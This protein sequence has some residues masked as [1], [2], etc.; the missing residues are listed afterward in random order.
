[1]NIG[2]YSFYSFYNRNRLFLDCSSPIGD[3]LIYPYVFMGRY[4]VSRGHKVS[5]IDMEPL[6]SYDAIVFL[7]YPTR[8]NKFFRRLISMKNAPPLYLITCEPEILRPDNWKKKNHLFFKKILTWDSRLVDKVKYI[9]LPLPNKIEKNYHYFNLKNKI[10]FCTLISSNKFSNYPG[11]LYSERIKMIRW[12]EKFHPEKFDLYGVDWD[13]L[14][15]PSLGK[16]NFLLSALYRKFPALPKIQHYPSYKGKL[17]SKKETLS[18][19]RY[20]ICFEN[21]MANGY[22][23]EKIFDCFLA[24][25]IPIYWGAPEI[26]SLI[27]KNTFIDI[28]KFSSYEELFGYISTMSDVEYQAYLDAIAYFLDSKQIYPWTAENFACII[29]KEICCA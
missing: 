28:H 4:L 16:L 2:F 29:E 6:A 22:V 7:D 9:S 3:D 20:A 11:E 5:T 18:L 21:V 1:M 23:T 12:F 10:H 13:R 15:I 25:V 17:K 24:G 8:F 14:F 19:Y 27:P 26:T